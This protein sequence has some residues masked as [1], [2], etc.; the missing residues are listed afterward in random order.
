M[1]PADAQILSKISRGDQEAFELLFD[2]YFH[3]ISKT[4][5]VILKDSELAKDLTHDLLLKLWIDREKTGEIKNLRSYL[6]TSIKN[7]ALNV[8]SKTDN[9]GKLNIKY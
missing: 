6:L 7:S 5:Y 4:A 3:A 2:K 9:H 8:I 1:D